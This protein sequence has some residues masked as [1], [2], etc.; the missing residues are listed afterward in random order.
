MNTKISHIPFYERLRIPDG[1]LLVAGLAYVLPAVLLLVWKPILAAA[2]AVIPLVILLISH[3]PV[4]LYLLVAATFVFFPWEGWITFLPGDVVAFFLIL[5][6]LVDLIR[7]GKRNTQNRLTGVYIFYLVVSL[8]SIALEG[9]TGLSLRFFGRQIILFATFLAVVHFSSRLDIR[10][11]FIVFVLAAAGNSVISTFHFLSALGAIRVFGI[12]GRGFGD[13]AAIGL[14]LGVMLYLWSSDIRARIFWGICCLLITGGLMATQ[15]R[16]SI[17]TAGWSVAL[18]I[19][20]ALR[21]A[22]PF[23]AP[24]PRKN[25]LLAGGLALIAIPLRLSICL[26]SRE[27]PIVL[28]T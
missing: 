7:R 23:S 17:I 11:V 10:M 3:G 21:S 1:A 27:F 2:F 16:A 25:L 5:A 26:Y 19:F 9:F 18:L 13:H 20:F 12:A 22:K 24:W 28:L 4:A 15:T 14:I 6:F 8:V